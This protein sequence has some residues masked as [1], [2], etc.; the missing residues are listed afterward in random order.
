M[1][2]NV[3][4]ILCSDNT[5]YTGISTDVQRRFQE[6]ATPQGRAGAKYFRGRRPLRIIYTEGGLDR[7]TAS[8]REAAIK[9][10]SR[11]EKLQLAAS[12]SGSHSMH[13]IPMPEVNR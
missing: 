11:A 2:W 9:L 3:Y 10:L 5:L 6:H 7:S 1:E 8:R 13:D 4:I 12:W